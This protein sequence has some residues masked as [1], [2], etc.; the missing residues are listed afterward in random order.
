MYVPVSHCRR[1]N[2]VH[3]GDKQKAGQ[4]RGITC[5][6]IDF[7]LLMNHEVLVIAS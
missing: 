1:N 4:E 3:R 6:T 2:K 5:I 7:P